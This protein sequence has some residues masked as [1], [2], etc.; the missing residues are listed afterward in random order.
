MDLCTQR[1][2][3]RPAENVTAYRSDEMA[4]LLQANIGLSTT[5]SLIFISLC[6]CT[7]VRTWCNRV[8]RQN[9]FPW[10]LSRKY[11]FPDCLNTSGLYST[12][13]SVPYVS[14][15]WPIMLN[16]NTYTAMHTRS[17]T[18]VL[19]YVW[20]TDTGMIHLSHLY[21]YTKSGFQRLSLFIPP[22]VHILSLDICSRVHDGPEC[23]C[24]T[25]ATLNQNSVGTDTERA[26]PEGQK[27]N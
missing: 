10:G 27:P 13:Q 17:D 21:I 7:E 3:D 15:P 19:N 6:P 20:H 18:Q 23:W 1:V 12:H 14:R 11:V 5:D 25:A 4:P 22:R 16:L 8:L 9:S 2:M 24:P 26:A